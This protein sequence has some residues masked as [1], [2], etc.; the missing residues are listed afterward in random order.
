MKAWFIGSI[1]IG[2]ETSERGDCNCIPC[3]TSYPT[4]ESCPG[5]SGKA[6]ITTSKLQRVF[7][8]LVKGIFSSNQWLHL[9][10]FH[11]YGHLSCIDLYVYHCISICY[12]YLLYDTPLNASF[13]WLYDPAVPAIDNLVYLASGLQLVVAD[14][15]PPCSNSQS[16]HPEWWSCTGSYFFG[17]GVEAGVSEGRWNQSKT[18]L[19]VMIHHC[20]RNLLQAEYSK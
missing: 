4:L 13:L 11:D 5:T 17:I 2:L 8:W 3:K 9:C 10:A 20:H 15:P 18:M 7:S 6:L 16:F 19:Y 14:L 1:K 12:I